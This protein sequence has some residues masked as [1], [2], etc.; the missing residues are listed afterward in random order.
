MLERALDKPHVILDKAKGNQ[1]FFLTTR[2]PL[3]FAQFEIDLFS[4]A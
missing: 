4:M 3:A 1:T 2:E